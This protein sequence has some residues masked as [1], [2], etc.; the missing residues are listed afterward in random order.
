[1]KYLDLTCGPI[2]LNPKINLNNFPL[3]SDWDQDFYHLYDQTCQFINQE[4]NIDHT[5]LV[6]GEG[7]ITLEMAVNNL[8]YPG[9]KVLVIENGYY[10]K[11]FTDFVKEKTNNYQIFKSDY[12]QEFNYQ[13]FEKFL[14]LNHDFKIATLVFVD[15]PTAVLNDLTKVVKILKKYNIMV[16]IDAISGVFIHPIDAKSLDIDLICATSHKTL[17][18]LPGISMI[19]FSDKVKEM[20]LANKHQI[21]SYYLSM[22]PFLTRKNTDLLPY[23]MPFLLIDCLNQSLKLLAQD[24]FFLRHKVLATALK[25]A[26]N[27]LNFVEYNPSSAYTVT[28]IYHP[29]ALEIHQFLL[30][31]HQILCSLG[32]EKDK[33]LTLRIG[34]MNTNADY[35]KLEKF[36]QAFDDYLKTKQITDKS[37]T[38]LFKKHL[39]ELNQF[40]NL[41]LHD[42]II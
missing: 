24:F 29:K 36:C 31:K 12:H 39:S 6:N 9:D 3:N 14:E 20:I 15:T 23:T 37:L 21:K 28:A 18:A 26:L 42:L 30:E 5:I 10:G 2:T 7:I 25:K 17:A 1:M 4:L 22:V 16:I 35:T 11:Y 8:I 27:D 34:H 41:S 13:A 33:N 19:S 32:L 38:V 40:Y